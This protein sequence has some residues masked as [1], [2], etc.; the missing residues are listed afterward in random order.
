MPSPKRGRR[1]LPEKEPEAVQEERSASR[2]E[3]GSM[4]SAKPQE[5]ITRS[6][7][8]EQR[9]ARSGGVDFA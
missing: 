5:A 8:L 2:H 7:H 4:R 3:Q 1:D 9:R 6:Q